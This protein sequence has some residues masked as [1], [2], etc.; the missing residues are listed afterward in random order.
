MS[1]RTSGCSRWTGASRGRLRTARVSA[2]RTTPRP[3]GSRASRKLRGTVVAQA[4]DTDSRLHGNV[5]WT[6][7]GIDSLSADGSRVAFAF[8]ADPHCLE[9]WDVPARR[10]VRFAENACA[11]EA[12][13]EEPQTITGLALAGRRLAW[14]V[15]M[16][17]NHINVWVST[18]TEVDQRI[19]TRRNGGG[20]G[21]TGEDRRRRGYAVFE[22]VKPPR[23]RIVRVLGT[24]SKTLVDLRGT[25]LL[26]AS[27]AGILRRTYATTLSDTSNGWARSSKDPCGDAR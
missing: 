1:E 8:D 17:T 2:T 13:G 25:E 27:D 12:L 21:V 24:T 23:T 22:S 5:L 14:E 6:K 20:Y 19:R 18:A 4:I 11:S 15:S 10:L 7:N 16:Q 3:G 26:T 9:L